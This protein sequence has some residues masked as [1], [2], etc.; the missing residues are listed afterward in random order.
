MYDEHEFRGNAINIVLGDEIVTD[1]DISEDMR[2]IFGQGYLYT[3][4]TFLKFLSK[5]YTFYHLHTFALLHD[6]ALISEKN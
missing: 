4:L 6:S 1:I 2:D 3:L 5:I